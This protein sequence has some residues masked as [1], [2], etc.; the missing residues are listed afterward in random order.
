[1]LAPRVVVV[2]PALNEAPVIAHVVRD[3]LSLN[4]PERRAISEVL[5][6][7]NGSTDG[8]ADRACEAGAKVVFASKRGYGA[9]C[10]RLFSMN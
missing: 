3:L 1:M 9:A 2:V 6:C 7:D 5:V 4:S 10:F 8:T